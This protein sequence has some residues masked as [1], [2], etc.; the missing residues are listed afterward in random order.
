MYKQ[1]NND[2]IIQRNVYL[3]NQDKN[4]LFVPTSEIMQHTWCTLQNK[5]YQG[6]EIHL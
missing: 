1:Y 3:Q 6:L 5:I 2:L 4:K